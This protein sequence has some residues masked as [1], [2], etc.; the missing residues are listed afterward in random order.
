[1]F[2]LYIFRLDIR[3]PAM[4]ANPPAELAQLRNGT[5][6]SLS[7]VKITRGGSVLLPNTAGNDAA[8]SSDVVLSFSVP[9][10]GTAAIFGVCVLGN[11]SAS[12]PLHTSTADAADVTASAESERPAPGVGGSAGGVPGSGTYAGGVCVGVNIT[13]GSDTKTGRR[14]VYS[15][16]GTEHGT[17]T[18]G[19]HLKSGSVNHT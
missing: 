17:Q 7:D 9:P 2:T 5:L 3:I 16:V 6:A 4:V 14:V 13:A 18:N 10:E 1:M 8:A 11:A 19:V 15:W 12:A